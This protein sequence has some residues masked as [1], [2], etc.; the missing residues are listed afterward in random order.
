[1]K[2]WIAALLA[3]VLL[4]QALPWTAFA[5]T[6][7]LITDDELAT[8]FL[9]AGLTLPAQADADGAIAKSASPAKAGVYRKGMEPDISWDART[10]VDYIDGILSTDLH[11]LHDTL[12]R[13]LEVLNRMK[14]EDPATYNRL[15]AASN[16]D[17]VYPWVTA[18]LEDVEGV[19]EEL[20]FM[21]DRVS[22]DVV[23]I[24]QIAGLLKSADAPVYAHEKVRY[25]E[26]IRA[27]S[28]DI[29][30]ARRVS[31]ENDSFYDS[32]LET[33]NE[34]VYGG[35]E[36][37]VA[38]YRNMDAWLAE[39]FAWD[40]GVIEKSVPVST[41]RKSGN[42]LSRLSS[43]DRVLSKADSAK[44]RL[45]VASENELTFQF[46][47]EDGKGV[48]GVK[49]RV[50]DARA[51][52][53]RVYEKTTD[54]LG[55]V[56]FNAN[57]FIA[58]DEKLVVIKLDVQ[59]EAQ[60]YQDIG[61]PDLELKRGAVFSM[62][63][64]QLDAVIAKDG[65]GGSGAYV[66]SAT[67]NGHDILSSDYEMLFSVLNDMDF[68]IQ[69][70]VKKPGETGAI[71]GLEPQ[72][73]YCKFKK[74]SAS[75]QMTQTQ[76]NVYSHNDSDTWL[77]LADM[78]TPRP[79]DYEKIQPTSRS[80]NTFTFRG[81]W[82]QLLS[83]WVSKQYAPYFVLDGGKN[84]K[85]FQTRLISIYSKVDMPVLDGTEPTSPLN[86]LFKQGLGFSFKIPVANIVVEFN[87]PFKS[88][89]WPKITVD[90]AGFYT[91]AIGSEYAQGE[92]NDPLYQWKSRDRKDYKDRIKAFEKKSYLA[93]QLNE[94]GTAY[95]F[96]EE[97]AA[98]FMGEAKLNMGFFA[99]ISG[100]Y[101]SDTDDDSTLYSGGG[102]GGFTLIFSYDWTM[103][104]TLLWVPM[105]VNF[106]FSASAGFGLGFQ[107]SF[108][109]RNN[110]LVDYT[111]SVGT[112]T[113]TIRFA[114]TL[115]LG[116]G[117]KDVACA[118]GS[119]T[120]ALSVAYTFMPQHE[121]TF[122]VDIT[123]IVTLGMQLLFLKATHKVW[124]LTPPLNLYNSAD[125]RK[126]SL[127]EKAVAKDAPKETR[128]VSQWPDRYPN[129][130][131]TA[132]RVFENRENIQAGMKVAVC[133]GQPFVFYLGTENTSGKRLRRLC[134]TNVNT[135]ESGDIQTV[136]A[137]QRDIPD[138]QDYAFDVRVDGDVIFVVC[139]CTRGFDENGKPLPNVAGEARAYMSAY[140][141]GLTVNDKGRLEG[142]VRNDTFLAYGKVSGNITGTACV[143]NPTLD[144][145]KVTTVAGNARSF[146]LY[147]AFG[148]ME[149]NTAGAICFYFN[150]AGQHDLLFSTDAAV[151]NAMGA[152]YERS[153]VRSGM[154]ARSSFWWPRR[155]NNALV[156]GSF[157]ALSRPK[158]GASGE[159]AIELYDWDMNCADVRSKIDKKTGQ[160]SLIST[161]RQAIVLDK[162]DIDAF[163][164]VQTPDPDGQRYAQT[165]FYTRGETLT[166]KAATGEKVSQT[167]K[168]LRSLYIEPKEGG[169]TRNLTFNVTRFDYDVNLPTGTFRVA[170]LGGTTYLYW[171]ATAPKKKDSD[172]TLWR[173]SG[174]TYDPST[175][176]VSD[177]MVLTEFSLPDVTYNGKTTGSV[178]YDVYLTDTGTGYLTSG[179]MLQEGD[180]TAALPPLSLY[181]FPLSLKPVIDVRGATLAHTVVQPGDFIDVSFAL[182]NE[183]NMGIASFDIDVM[184]CTEEG[185]DGQVVETL[186]ANCLEPQGSTL[187]MK[188]SGKVVKQGKAAFYRA[189]EF[190]LGGAQRDWVTR[191][192]KIAYKV[193]N[194]KLASSNKSDSE[195]NY[196]KTDVLMPG[197][198]AS[199]CGAIQ[200]PASWSG[201]KLIKLRVRSVSTYAKWA[202]AIHKAGGAIPKGA[203]V[204]YDVPITYTRNDRTG[205]ME[206]ESSDVFAKGPGDMVTLYPESMPAPEDVTLLSDT[207]DVD[208]DHR[209]WAD[210]DGEEMLDI[211]ILNH[212]S[213]GTPIHLSC[214]VYP[215]NQKEPYYV[216]LPYDYS[217]V[218]TGKAQ[219]LTLPL[220]QVVDPEVYHQAIIVIEA[221]NTDESVVANNTFNVY[222]AHKG[223]SS[224]L[225]IDLEPA[226]FTVREGGRARFTTTAYGGT[227]PR[228]Y[229]WQ[230]LVDG[231]WKD[232]VN[233]D[234]IQGAD[235]DTLTLEKVP[236]AWNG[237]Q[238][239]CVVTDADGGT[240][241]TRT[242]T[243]RVLRPGAGGS[244]DGSDSH[245]DTGDHSNLPLTLATALAALALLIL[246]RRR[247]R[248][249]P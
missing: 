178:P 81:K 93:R 243:L 149:G 139:C 143:T 7:D 220:S 235:T 86:N 205:R 145:V 119:A 195:T 80:G 48:A 133:K 233:G 16:D 136:I 157:V 189:S 30:E 98:K 39:L 151:K 41:I 234:G 99:M 45:R 180:S 72:M 29:A 92:N 144:G 88:H 224:A 232:L 208:I 114:L 214:A 85:R 213:N 141:L 138:M 211:V 59:A 193:T 164:L 217:L 128:Q 150:G 83:P 64:T 103:A 126:K 27:A 161:N 8:A 247:Y 134:W 179:P 37:N 101:K 162:G 97:S 153:Y 124:E 130:A 104:F 172:P 46:R 244:G 181:S 202:A 183:G 38:A 122:R 23:T 177:P 155:G 112:L 6:G 94:M 148:Q 196:V 194:G 44:V 19:R 12:A 32:F 117:I 5:A 198:L 110:K 63:L 146:E 1:M 170:T 36:G 203:A 230:V 68:D 160:I 185:G 60:G 212:V 125:P 186:H 249:T 13:A 74:P 174:V 25:S 167:R 43:G 159:R 201:E 108:L 57:D 82:K 219:T 176:T 165:I 140:A 56:A 238:T 107:T 71:S 52:K 210:Y 188:D 187:T 204:E 197:A 67:F 20:R 33:A 121:A 226:D 111:V 3:L 22:D 17:D 228:R 209:V 237:R 171:M 245:P 137:D 49:V 105:Y 222:L 113:I 91:I 173:I 131:P 24:E 116:I 241:I 42:R 147:G 231:Q 28:A 21:R 206:L 200:I 246:L 53:G 182:M 221:L 156:S 40:Q 58:N 184:E 50:Q 239:R 142:D 9:R 70:T 166:G 225:A 163:E 76:Q 106:N 11:T 169:G 34:A 51:K 102:I 123:V 35:Y 79:S 168:R 10:L 118:W 120:G 192:E 109:R 55:T 115:A 78:A 95:R 216:S 62:A 223:T 227:E 158:N 236:L 229:Q 89:W 75:S 199:Y 127:M 77:Y 152:G 207:Y 96:Y 242:A 132:R 18:L 90:P 129:L 65:E 218:S 248:N 190:A 47:G 135:N 73:W 2:K 66:Y 15:T 175:N 61:I 84:A 215:D 26:Q 154:R 14:D 240:V 54:S 69:I 191:R 87:P 100:S 31:I 4:S